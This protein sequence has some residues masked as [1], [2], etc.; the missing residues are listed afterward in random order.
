MKLA[1]A[2]SVLALSTATSAAACELD[3]LFEASYILHAAVAN[4]SDSSAKIAQDV[5][6]T[7]RERH[8]ELARQTFA[9][10]FGLGA[11]V[12]GVT[13]TVQPPVQMVAAQS[14]EQSGPERASRAQ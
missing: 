8:M 2:I 11:G 5:A 12:T 7:Q 1:V 13:P 9:A 4:A 10:R 14:A 3:A 6:E